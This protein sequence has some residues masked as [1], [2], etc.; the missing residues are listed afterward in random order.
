MQMYNQGANMYATCQSL[1]H[2]SGKTCPGSSLFEIHKEQHVPLSKL[3]VGKPATQADA[4][5][6]WMDPSVLGKCLAQAR[7]SGWN[8]GMT[9]WQYPHLTT[10]MLQAAKQAAGWT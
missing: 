9:F 10:S 8:A 1:L 4:S 7:Q 6:G 5:N 3:V 2:S